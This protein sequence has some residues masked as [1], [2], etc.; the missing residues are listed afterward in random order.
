VLNA[1]V[2]IQLRVQEQIVDARFWEMYSLH[3]RTGIRSVD[4]KFLVV[5]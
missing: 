5:S 4:H 2:N 1:I 3:E